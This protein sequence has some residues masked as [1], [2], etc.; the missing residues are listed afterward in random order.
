MNISGS[1]PGWFRTATGVG[2]GP[3]G[4]IFVADFYNNRV[5]EFSR[6]SKLLSIIV[7]KDAN[8]RQLKLPT[9]AANDDAGNVYIV[10]FGNNSILK[11]SP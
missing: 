1:R 9:D 8:P 7:G 6:D 11:Y 4:H 2:I 5:Q 3:D 10:D